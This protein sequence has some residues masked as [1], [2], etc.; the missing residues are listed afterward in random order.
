[1]GRQDDVG[2][3]IAVGRVL[4]EELL[5]TAFALHDVLG[6]LLDDL[7]EDA[8]PGEDGAEV[9]LEMVVGSCLPAL[10]AAGI[11][12]CEVA[13]ALVGAVRDRVLDDL[14]RAAELARSNS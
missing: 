12:E 13:T 11:E 4:I 1:M 7:P 5:R 2:E 8:F 9:L 6:S 3:A 14:R 10:T